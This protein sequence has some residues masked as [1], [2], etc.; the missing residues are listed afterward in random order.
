MTALQSPHQPTQLSPQ[1]PTGKTVVVNG[2][3]IHFLEAGKRSQTVTLLLHGWPTSSH[4]WRKVMP[5]LAAEQWV[6]APDLPGFGDSD[7]PTEAAFD[8]NFWVQFIDQFLDAIKADRVNLVVHDLGGPIGLCWAVNRPEKVAKLVLLN[9]IVYAKLNWSAK[10]FVSMTF[11]PIISRWMTKPKTVAKIVQ[12]GMQSRLSAE[13]RSHYAAPFYQE[14]ARRTLLLSVRRLKPKD[15]A[16]IDKK[17]TRLTM[18][19]ACIYGEN[20]RLLLDVA[21]TMAKVKR[22]LPQAEV[23]SL[24]NCGHFLQEDEPEKLA[25]AMATFLTV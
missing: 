20:D 19:V 17:L 25:S 13:D 6:I 8:F 23:S 11:L 12:L 15:A 14:A 10:L 18:P 7:K 24:A 4:L 3:N 5:T 22:D 21:D 16:E 9:T 2:M 1:S